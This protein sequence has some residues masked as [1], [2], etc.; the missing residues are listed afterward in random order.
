MF[1][2]AGIAKLIQPLSVKLAQM[3]LPLPG[4]C[5]QGIGIIEVVGALGLILPGLTRIRPRL[6]SL[7]ASG[8]LLEMIWAAVVTLLA[9]KGT[10]ALLPVI[11]GVLCA[12]VAYGRRPW[13]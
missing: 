8:L 10:A 6:T 7:A 2:A 12:A 5:V 3:P 1:L 9:S 13:R 4:L 11:T